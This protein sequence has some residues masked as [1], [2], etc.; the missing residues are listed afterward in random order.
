MLYLIDASIYVFRAWFSLPED[1]QDSDGKQTNALYGF[2]RF[3]GDFLE[4]TRPEYVAVAFDTSHSSC[5]R[6]D[7]Y[8]EYKANRDPAPEELKQQFERCREVTRA[9]GLR[10]FAEQRYEADDIIGTLVTRMR[11]EGMRSTILSRD[12]DLTQLLDA[13][14]VMWDFVGG[15]RVRYKDV[16]DKYGVRAEQMVDYLALAGDSVDNIPGV[17]GVGTKTAAALLN[18]FDSMDDIYARLDEVA[19]V[20]VRGAATLASKLEA[21]RED[22]RLSRRLS[23]IECDVPMQSEREQLRRKAPD[24]DALNELYDRADFGQV[25][26]RQAERIAAHI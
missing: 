20:A 13:G 21:G 11:R 12:K 22:A 18:H 19:N 24:M 17:R 9:L 15:K 26:R 23:K 10:D 4:H 2:T 16:P 14:D 7:I 3:L 25:L 8:P 1:M 5:F 6:N